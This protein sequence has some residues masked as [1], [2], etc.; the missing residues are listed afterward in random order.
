MN[1][2]IYARFSSHNQ[3]E[4]SIEGQVK[5][6]KEYAERNNFNII[7]IYK[8][9]ARSGTS[10]NRLQFQKMIKDSS[11]KRFE[12]VIV[13]SMDKF[14]INRYDSVIYKRKLKQNGV[15]VFSTKG[16]I[17]NDPSRILM[18]SVMEGL[19]E[20][21]SIEHSQKIKEGI[22]RKKKKKEKIANEG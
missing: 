8:D 3:T 6:C 15:S 13:Y 18:E 11:K 10:D 16:N 17:E 20:Y 9:E 2:V 7:K 21:Y 22:A 5:I 19:I 12:A 1:V 14:A 4:Q